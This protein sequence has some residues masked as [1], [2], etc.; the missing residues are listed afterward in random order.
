MSEDGP[1]PRG[2]RPAAVRGGAGWRNRDHTQG[3]LYA[4]LLV[5]AL[6]LIGSSM[7][8]GVVYQLFDLAFLSRLGE[9]QLTAVVITNRRALALSA[10][11][12]GFF[13]TRLQIGEAIESIR[14][15]SSIATITT[16]RRLLV[17]RGP[18]GR[19]SEERRSGR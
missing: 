17:F 8:F 6:P 18:T 14:A 15:V 7:L 1:E 9:A 5:L 16:S 4:S 10:D 11:S 12:G 2:D 13:E 19:W 3:S